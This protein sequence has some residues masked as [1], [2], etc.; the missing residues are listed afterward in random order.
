MRKYQ[1]EK[2]DWWV[3]T[4]YRSGY[5][6]ATQNYNVSQEYRELLKV[7]VEISLEDLLQ[8]WEI[9]D[10]MAWEDHIGSD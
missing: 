9:I 1:D 6:W 7:G 8:S 2:S 4:A 5:G 3:E 10:H